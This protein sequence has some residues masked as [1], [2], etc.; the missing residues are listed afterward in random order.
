MGQTSGSTKL[1]EVVM[2]CKALLLKMDRMQGDFADL[3]T[4]AIQNGVEPDH[5]FLNADGHLKSALSLSSVEDV[6]S[7]VI[8]A[9]QTLALGVDA[10]M[11]D[12][13]LVKLRGHLRD[14]QRSTEDLLVDC[15]RILEE[16]AKVRQAHM[17]LERLSW[18]RR[19]VR[20][21][22]TMKSTK[23]ATDKGGDHDS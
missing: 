3:V 7:C 16:A 4:K 17:S 12:K 13:S 22:S 11:G 10:R 9:R 23:E 20:L 8:K 5:H 21:W 14:Y 15:G 2:D 18:W 19:V 1:G 6:H